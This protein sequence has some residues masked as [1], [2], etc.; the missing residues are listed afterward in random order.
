MERFASSYGR[1]LFP[2]RFGAGAATTP[3]NARRNH[4]PM[5]LAPG[6]L[7]LDLGAA[8]YRMVRAAES[9]LDGIRRPRQRTR[10]GLACE[11]TPAGC[12]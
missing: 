12:N 3:D 7:E 4:V 11:A 2:N 9:L 5:S 10:P 6:A 1:A 8:I